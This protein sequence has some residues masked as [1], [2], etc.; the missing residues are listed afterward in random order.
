[1]KKIIICIITLFVLAV[2]FFFFIY[3]TLKSTIN[4]EMTYS[5]KFD[6]IT[7]EFSG[8]SEHFSFNIGKVYLA[9]NERRL[10]IDEFKQ[11]KKISN[12]KKELVYV[13]FEDKV[14]Q[15][16]EN[17]SKLNKINSKLESLRF[18]EGG[19]VCIDCEKSILDSIN[20]ENF[21]DKIKIIIEYCTSESCK[22][23]QFKLKYAY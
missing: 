7:F 15:T 5:P 3:I 18:Y 11:T 1:M 23:E 19:Q 13:Y 14:W 22:T 10:Y 6:E 20:E 17:D 12:L 2:L 4:N 9:G 16:R 8:N 21:K